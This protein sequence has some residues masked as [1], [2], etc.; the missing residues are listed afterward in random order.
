MKNCSECRKFTNQ[1]CEPLI[2]IA[3]PELPLQRV[4]TDLLELKGHSYLLLVDY[5]S[6]FIEVARLNRTTA[7]EVILHTKGVFARHGIPEVVAT[8]FVRGLR[9]FCSTV[10]V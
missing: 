7:D 2:P 3:L 10:P 8:I 5:Y 4:G 1:R 9:S 6:Q